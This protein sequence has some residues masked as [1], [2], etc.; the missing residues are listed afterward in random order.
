M[1]V[2]MVTKTMHFLNCRNEQWALP[3]LWAWSRTIPIVTF[4]L[5]HVSK[6]IRWRLELQCSSSKATLEVLDSF[7]RLKTLF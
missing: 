7:E 5:N 2:A 1:W 6:I 3:G 4:A